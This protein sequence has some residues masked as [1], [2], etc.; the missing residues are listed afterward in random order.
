M[1]AAKVPRRTSAKQLHFAGQCARGNLPAT[2][3]PGNAQ[4][5]FPLL[6]CSLALHRPTLRIQDA[7]WNL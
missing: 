6:I 4:A 2:T 7:T 5:A 1:G 3:V